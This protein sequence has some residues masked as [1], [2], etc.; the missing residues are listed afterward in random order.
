MKQNS[1]KNILENKKNILDS[2]KN[3]LES[4]KNILD[5]KIFSIL[6]LIICYL[7][8]FGVS[9]SLYFIMPF[10][11][12]L[13]KYILI[14]LAATF[15]IYIFS[16]IFQNS[17]I[18]DPYWSVL[19]MVM[20]PFFIIQEIKLN[21][22]QD[23]VLVAC[24]LIMI[25]IVEIWGLRL[26]INCLF[27]FKN[28]K[29]ED[30]RY[31]NIKNKHPKLWPLISLLGIHLMPT[32]VVFIAMLPIFLY[33]NT[34][35]TPNADG[36]IAVEINGT[37]VISIIVALASIIIETIADIEM[38]KFKKDKNNLGQ[39]LK[40]GLWKNS[41]HPNY[42]GEILFWFSMFLFALSV[43]GNYWILIFSPLVVF[44]LFVAISIPMMEKRQLQN[45]KDYEEY[46]K[47]T[48][49]L[50]PIFPPSIKK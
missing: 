8:A 1:N 39:I 37:Y 35:I 12:A 41:R 3:I 40:T 42:F 32:I 14:D 23:K 45:K 43:N 30:W 25:I 26:T 4:K 21:F 6:I 13:V 19:P 33:A 44:I 11:N 9:F 7:I 36:K 16:M 48:N 17:S 29:A 20:V 50:L 46:K 38:N 47:T 15:I 10:S 18:Y 31:Q 34:F 24:M 49:P 22:H 2:K 5:S 28:L 27:R